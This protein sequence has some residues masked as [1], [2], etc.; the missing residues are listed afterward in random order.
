M[1]LFRQAGFSE[2][3]DILTEDRG[4]GGHMGR[5]ERPLFPDLDP[6]HA[7]ALRL[8]QLRES[9]GKP[10]YSAMA[11]RTG[12]S[13]TALSDAAGGDTVPGWETVV[14]F[15]SFCKWHPDDYLIDWERVRALRDGFAERI[16]TRVPLDQQLPTL[17]ILPRQPAPI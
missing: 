17:T 3:V 4:I 6:L 11:R 7:F 9:A 13:R 1:T 8:R 14:A 12:R 2:P 16:T 5:P 15:V 10:T